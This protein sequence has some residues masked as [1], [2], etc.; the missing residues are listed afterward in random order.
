MRIDEPTVMDTIKVDSTTWELRT[1][2]PLIQLSG[3]DFLVFIRPTHSVGE[4]EA[5]VYARARRYVD[6]A[7]TVASR[8]SFRGFCEGLF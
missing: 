4:V 1:E 5:H 6:Y 7:D 8:R 3:V 2:G